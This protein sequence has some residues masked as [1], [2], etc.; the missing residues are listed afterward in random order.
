MVWPDVNMS[1]EN[2]NGD[3]AGT[4]YALL[5]E[6]LSAKHPAFRNTRLLRDCVL[7]KKGGG[8]SSGNWW[9]G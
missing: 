6:P 3:K 7:E 5:G 9:T 8:G 1:R 4:T 2:A